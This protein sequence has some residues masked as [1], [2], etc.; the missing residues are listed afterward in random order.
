[1]VALNTMN[2]RG[3]C[4][5]SGQVCA[6][7]VGSDTRHLTRC[8]SRRSHCQDIWYTPTM[9]NPDDCFHNFIWLCI[10]SFL[11]D[12]MGLLFK[13]GRKRG[14]N[15]AEWG[16]DRRTNMGWVTVLLVANPNSQK[17]ICC[18]KSVLTLLFRYL[19]DAQIRSPS[20]NSRN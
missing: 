2:L 8:T 16:S 18:T 19:K 4:D 14:P 3:T 5:T 1:M 20:P 12:F 6:R 15:R 17:L 11:I 7:Q 9:S 13:N 10:L